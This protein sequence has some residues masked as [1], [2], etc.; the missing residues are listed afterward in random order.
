[1]AAACSMII[2]ITFCQP[3]V[4]RSTPACAWTPLEQSLPAYM[5]PFRTVEAPMRHRGKFREGPF[6]QRN[7]MSHVYMAFM[8]EV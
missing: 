7:M 2:S 8:A 3:S 6:Q 1:M 4:F 5:H